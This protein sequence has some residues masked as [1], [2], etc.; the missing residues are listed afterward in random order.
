MAGASWGRPRGFEVSRTGGG[1][2]DPCQEGCGG[3][4]MLRSWVGSKPAGGQGGR[5]VSLGLPA[6]PGSVPCIPRSS[7]LPWMSLHTCSSFRQPRRPRSLSALILPLIA[8]RKSQS[9]GGPPPPINPPACLCLRSR[10]PTALLLS[11]QAVSCP[12]ASDPDRAAHPFSCIW[13]V[14][15]Y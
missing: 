15:F 4:E 3:Q 9:R 5:V 6:Q 8:V 10:P 1:T 14:S 13:N 7:S 11:E 12:T 2:T